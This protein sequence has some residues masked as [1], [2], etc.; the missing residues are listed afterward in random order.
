MFHGRF[1]LINQ[2]FLVHREFKRLLPDTHVPKHFTWANVLKELKDHKLTMRGWV[3][4]T[5]WPGIDGGLDWGNIAKA[6]LQGALAFLS[7]S[8]ENTR[9]IRLEKWSEATAGTLH[10][11]T[12]TCAQR[13]TLLNILVHSHCS[14]RRL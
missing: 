5:L 2:I 14:G 11:P 10:F 13:I 4:G 3:D 9:G 7:S 6:D 1:F 8:D 12:Y